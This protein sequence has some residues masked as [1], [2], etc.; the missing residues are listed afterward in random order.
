[1]DFYFRALFDTIKLANISLIIRNR[2]YI[3]KKC[4]S[5]KMCIQLVPIFNHLKTEYLSKIMTLSKTKYIDKNEIIFS[6]GDM[7]DNLFIV[8]KG[9][10][11]VYAIDESGKEHIL[12]IM[13]S[14]DYMGEM[15]LFL[16]SEHI[17]FAQATEETTICTIYKEDL[18]KLL[19]EHPL[20]SIK[21]LEEFAQR[22]KSSQTQA[23]RMVS[24]S[25]DKRLALYLIENLDDDLKVKINISRKDLANYLGMTPETISR[26]FKR[27]EEDNLIQQITSKEILVTNEEGLIN[28]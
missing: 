24:K 10:V 15:S 21:I 28:I 5:E 18:L 25:A 16:S 14:G 6:A 2:G 27:F 7:S 17:N 23:T 11:K 9:K 19:E 22:L 20:I 8:H 26:I 13:N 3:M 4:D 12:N 1:M